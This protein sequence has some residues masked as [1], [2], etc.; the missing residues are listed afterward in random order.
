MT[1]LFIQEAEAG[2][3]PLEL[4]VPSI[5]FE[6]RCLGA[7][8]AGFVAHR[9]RGRLDDG[10]VS[11]MKIAAVT[12]VRTVA[13]GFIL[14]SGCARPNVD[15]VAGSYRVSVGEWQGVWSSG[16][17]AGQN[18]V[19]G[20]GREPWESLPKRVELTDEPA[21]EGCGGSFRIQADQIPSRPHACWSISG[22]DTLELVWWNSSYGLSGIVVELVA[23]SKDGEW[24]GSAQTFVDMSPSVTYR[25]EVVMTRVR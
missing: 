14:A 18:T 24:R 7:P 19:G 1:R 13:I 21:G 5:V 16:A 22:R 9:N 6:L 12:Q 3:Q 20:A 17:L 11:Q 15:D 4:G 2:D 8:P 25:C 10:A 23:S